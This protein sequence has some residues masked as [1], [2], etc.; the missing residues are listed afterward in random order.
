[1]D[2]KITDFYSTIS[3][4]YFT[5]NQMF[6]QTDS[7]GLGLG[8]S[9]NVSPES[10]AKGFHSLTDITYRNTELLSDWDVS[11]RAAYQY[12]RQ[13]PYFKLFPNG[14]ILPVDPKGIL[15]PY[16]FER[17]LYFPEGTHMDVYLRDQIASIELIGIYLGLNK[18]YIRNGVGFKSMTEKNR[19]FNNYSADRLIECDWIVSGEKNE[20]IIDELSDLT[21]NLGFAFIQDEWSLLSSLD[22]ISGIRYDHYSDVGQTVNP[23]LA[24]VWEVNQRLTSKLL[25][26]K[27]FRAPSFSELFATSESETK[28]SSSNPDLSPEII[29]TLELAFDYRPI[30]KLRT[31]L[32]LFGLRA[33][34]MI[35]EIPADKIFEFILENRGEIDGYGFEFELEWDYRSIFSLH[36]GFSY[37][38]V[39]DRQTHRRVPY[40]PSMDF[41]FNPHWYILPDWSVDAQLFWIGKRV[42]EST[43]GRPN[44]SD[45]S[46]V[47]LTLR[48]HQQK[49]AWN[50]AIGIRNVLNTDA[51]EPAPPEVPHDIPLSGRSL[52][53]E[54]T[55]AF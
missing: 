27:A 10:N 51:F 15:N 33:K 55:Y 31:V 1:M 29:D 7:F 4:D 26:G 52:F 53:G 40:A 18:H 46:L 17:L 32:T 30:P 54:V 44:L 12:L 42:R 9:N 37:Q 23:R 49:T 5:I 43:D 36:S 14:A 3:K 22:L 20:I 41:Y 19:W 21:R 47:N 8:Y 38:H 2:Y 24:F 45:Y 34:D 50:I 48:Y 28:L 11:V 6:I 39:I 25:Y 13:E 16:S 35:V